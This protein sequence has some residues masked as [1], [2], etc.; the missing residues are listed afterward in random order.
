M[1]TIHD[2]QKLLSV[3]ALSEQL[4]DNA[5]EVINA[6]EEHGVRNTIDSL[7]WAKD[8][9]YHPLTTLS[10][11]HYGATLYFDFFV[12][13]NYL[14]A[15][16][17]RTNSPV[18]EDSSVALFI[19]PNP[20]DLTY[21][22]LMIN[23]IGTISGQIHRPDG[24]KSPIDPERLEA[25]ARY[26]SCGTRPFRELEGL[27][28]WNILVKIPLDFFGIVNPEFPLEMKGNF[29][30]C[31]S[32]TSQPHFLSWSSVNSDRPDFDRPDCF[33]RIILE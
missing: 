2:N 21:Y 19:Q 1:K 29:Y 3:P 4:S 12:R 14:R 31:A 30:K 8:Y 20:D 17:D 25:I 27:F 7:D 15:I 33:G 18:F 24:T 6:I 9:P 11:A 13:S 26:S 16:N 32:G 23:C 28:T 22:S 5:D 10:A